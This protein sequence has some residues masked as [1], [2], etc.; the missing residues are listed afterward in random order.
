M[1]YINPVR[2][3]KKED[4]AYFVRQQ[5]KLTGVIFFTLAFVL[6]LLYFSVAPKMMRLYANF[7]IAPHPF[8]K[9]LLYIAVL[10]I[11][12]LVFFG[13]QS[14]GKKVDKSELSKKLRAYKPREM[15]LSNKVLDMRMAYVAMAIAFAMIAIL[16][17]SVILPIY[18][19]TENL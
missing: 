14:F 9:A 5:Y 8:T 2:Y 16:T 12:V 13:L 7:S 19:L 3:I 15:I 18:N 1:V 6:G 11:V 4:A 10:S 17:A